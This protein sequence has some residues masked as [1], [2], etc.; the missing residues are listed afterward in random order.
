MRIEKPCGMPYDQFRMK[1]GF[2]IWPVLAGLC[3]FV[4][5]APG[6]DVPVYR[7]YTQPI[8]F[9]HDPTEASAL[10]RSAPDVLALQSLRDTQA[11]EGLMG[12]ETLL[13]LVFESG[14]S[15]LGVRGPSAP[16]VPPPPDAGQD[17]RRRQ[18]ERDRN[19]L[20]KSLT[21]PSLGQTGSNAATAVISGGAK[22]SSWGWLADGV[23]G[24]PGGESGQPAELQLEEELSA[25]PTP[26]ASSPDIQSAL[27]RDRGTAKADG[28][29][30]AKSEP[31]VTAA[32]FPMST[33]RSQKPSDRPADRS[34]PGPRDASSSGWGT[35]AS[36]PRTQSDPAVADLGQT[37]KILEEMTS[38]ARPDF[39]VLRDSLLAS[40]ALPPPQASGAGFGSRMPSTPAGMDMSSGIGLG[41]LGSPVPTEA[42]SGGASHPV[43]PSWKA[44]WDQ[45]MSGGPGSAAWGIHA[46]PA[47]ISLPAASFPTDPFR[48]GSGGYKPA[49]H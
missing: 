10:D 7:E 14:T 3:G 22:E 15:V 1:P 18:D 36:M 31:E 11:Q 2:V 21:L 49:W 23:A 32:S 13:D 38:R 48:A 25:T 47:P 37:R 42:G 44:G 40:P 29:E 20:A 27:R 45:N 33:D 4:P 39:A 12:K 8:V 34:G 46:D 5:V 6:R 41:S 35:S 9:H 17:A 16:P 19:W 28:K 26:M 24:Q 30:S 43:I